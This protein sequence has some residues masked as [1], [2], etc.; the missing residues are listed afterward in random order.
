MNKS[1]LEGGK[2][3]VRLKLELI[4]K[5]EL[6]V[7]PRTGTCLI[8]FVVWTMFQFCLGTGMIMEL[9][10]FCPDPSWPQSGLIWCLVL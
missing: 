4:K 6:L 3:R 8:N 5:L 1:Y 7:L 10:C 9:Y 2:N